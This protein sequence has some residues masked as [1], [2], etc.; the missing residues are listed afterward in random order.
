VTISKRALIIALGVLWVI[1]GIL[2]F[3]P[4]MF[5][6]AF[7]QQVILPNAVSQPLW[8][9]APILW[10]AG[11]AGAHIAAWN[12]LFA[13]LQTLLGVA[14][15]LRFKTRLTLVGTFLWSFIVWWVGEGFGGLLTGGALLATGAP[16]A[17]VFYVLVGIAL[18]PGKA[19]NQEERGDRRDFARWSLAILWFIG[20]A[21][22]LQPAYFHGSALSQ[23][24]S[25]GWVAGLIDG[26]APAATI[27]IALIEFLIGVGTLVPRLFREAAWAGIV[28]S[29]LF[30][31]VAQ[32]FGQVL[33][34][35]G[36][37]PNSGPMWVLL[38]LCAFPDLLSTSSFSLRLGTQP[39]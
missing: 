20:A 36:T 7:I 13:A 23:S 9:S 8:I 39:H 32:D 12:A 15:I 34:P 2:Q 1:D 38:T 22:H 16:G 3:K 5:T 11:I 17:I 28:L 10:A 33:S 26:H 14:L 31:W 18:W 21:L 30:W 24:F 29:L 37:D 4:T 27:V 19:P 25:A 6:P 35:L